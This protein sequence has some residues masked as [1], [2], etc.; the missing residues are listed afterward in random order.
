MQSLSK[1]FT[2]KILRASSKGEPIDADETFE[3]MRLRQGRSLENKPLWHERY[4]PLAQASGLSRSSKVDNFW[5]SPLAV[6]REWTIPVL[7][8]LRRLVLLNQDL[9]VSLSRNA[10]KSKLL[11]HF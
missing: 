8:L 6:C 5:P 2:R 9:I 1:K 11:H 4:G 3:L 10:L 7:D